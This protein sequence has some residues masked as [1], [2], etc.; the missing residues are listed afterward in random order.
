MA[1]EIGR[2]LPDKCIDDLVFIEKVEESDAI[3]FVKR[4]ENKTY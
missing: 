2:V 4:Y 1:K 3:V